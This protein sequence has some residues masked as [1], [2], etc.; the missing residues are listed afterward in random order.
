MEI[1][2]KQNLIRDYK[3][4][5]W[6]RKEAEKYAV[7]N[8]IA[9]KIPYGIKLSEPEINKIITQN[10][11]FNDYALIRREL[12]ERGYINRTRDCREYWRTE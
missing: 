9:L 6:P 3:I 5:R 4:I 12:I 1:S 11:L 7:L 8:F 10:I 2:N